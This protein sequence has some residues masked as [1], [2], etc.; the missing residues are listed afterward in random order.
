MEENRG[1]IEPVPGVRYLV[2]DRDVNLEVDLDVVEGQIGEWRKQGHQV[3]GYLL[4]IPVSRASTAHLDGEIRTY[5]LNMTFALHS[6]IMLYTK[7]NPLMARWYLEQTKQ[8]GLLLQT[9]DQF[10][11]CDPENR[12]RVFGQDIVRELGK[13]KSIKV[14]DGW[15]FPG[16]GAL[17]HLSLGEVLPETKNIEDRIYESKQKGYL[18]FEKIVGIE[19]KAQSFMKGIRHEDIRFEWPYASEPLKHLLCLTRH[20]ERAMDDGRRIAEK[21][22][23]VLQLLDYSLHTDE[24]SRV[25]DNFFNRGPPVNAL[26]ELMERIMDRKTYND[27]RRMA[28]KFCDVTQNGELVWNPQVL[29][30][31]GDYM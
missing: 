24:G 16:E 21:S 31:L 12:E 9:E 18:I 3:G 4:G 17:E 25:F 14:V 26:S 5:E 1:S 10:R 23:P 13:T 7:G 28:R 6:E 19:S 30:E 27:L 20:Y 11:A 15:C 8:N 2:V 29:G 22:D